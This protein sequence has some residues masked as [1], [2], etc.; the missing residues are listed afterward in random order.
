MLAEIMAHFKPEI[1]A[2]IRPGELVEA[3]AAGASRTMIRV[4]FIV[5]VANRRFDS[6]QPPSELNPDD[7]KGRKRKNASPGCPLC[8]RP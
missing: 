4:V 2:L 7:S 8:G 3:S 1:G 5:L 6:S